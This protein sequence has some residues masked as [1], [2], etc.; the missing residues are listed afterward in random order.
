MYIDT[1]NLIEIEKALKT[2]VIKG[3]T[4]NPTILKKEN[5]NRKEQIKEILSLGVQELFIQL[6]GETSEE[7][8]LDFENLK[9][10]EKEIG[11][12]LS[13]KVPLSFAGLETV[14]KIKKE[15]SSRVVLGTA[16]YS[17]DQAILGA[18]AG[19]D[20]LAPYVNRMQNNSIDS[21]LEISK[22]RTFIDDRNVKTKILAASF[23]NSNQV[24]DSLVNGAH[25]ATIPYD[26]LVQ[27]IDK[28]IALNAIKVFNEDGKVTI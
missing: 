15:D 25:T 28:Q 16:V 14:S 9:K 23:K 4:T 2:G 1:A 12:K 24:V 10:F 11:F 26:I 18:V 7:M 3:V 13:L 27:M 8:I 20:Y 17:S 21:I 6:L 5:K 22:I 19:C